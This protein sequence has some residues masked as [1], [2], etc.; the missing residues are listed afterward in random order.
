M[1]APFTITSPTNALAVGIY[2]LFAFYGLMLFTHVAVV[3]TLTFP[4]NEMW[5]TLLLIASSAAV[6]ATLSAPRRRDPDVSLAIELFA[7]ASLCTLLTVLSWSVAVFP[8]T[9]GEFPTTTFGLCI[10]F[11]LGFLARAVQIVKERR[12]IRNF[13][14]GPTPG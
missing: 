9:T 4:F 7:S 6:Y 5:G 8:T 13:R 11:T 1:K 12:N 14:N 3:R 10:I 2:A